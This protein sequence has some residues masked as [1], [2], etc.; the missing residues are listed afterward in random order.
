MKKKILVLGYFGF[1]NNELDGQTIKTRSIYELLIS[2]DKRRFSIEKF[3]TQKF[4]YSKVS[5]FKMLYELLRCNILVY[6]PAHKNLKYLFPLIY[7]IGKLKRFQILYFVVGGWL[8]EYLENKKLHI[9]LLS[10]IKAILTESNDLT[11]S[12]ITKYN[13]NNVRTFPNFRIHSFIPDFLESNGSLNV[14]FMGRINIMKGIDYVFYLAD[15]LKREIDK[16]IT[17]DFF[18]PIEK[19]DEDYFFSELEKYKNCYYK[20]VLDPEKIYS[21]LNNYDLMVF[22]TR[23]FTEGFPGSVLDAYISGLPV[24]TTHWKHATDFIIDGITG[25]IVPFEN[26]KDEFVRAVLTLYENKNLLYSMKNSAF[27]QSKAYSS[28]LAWGILTEYLNN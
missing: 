28:D 3:D 24:I 16:N 19:K 21:T 4:Q 15:Y 25:I 23:Y 1:R 10:K 12:L 18:G 14:V 9:S 26:G 8:E 11:Q 27:E 13:F 5:F 6:I 20:G 22:P 2:K 17:I 7:F